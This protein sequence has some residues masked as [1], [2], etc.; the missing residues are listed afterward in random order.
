MSLV[1]RE[2]TAADI[3]AVVPLH[4]KTWRATYEGL[5]SEKELNGPTYEI[6]ERQW[7]K[8]F[9]VAD[10]NRFH[11]VVE[12]ETG[13]L[14]GFAVGRPSDHPEFE[15]ELNKIYL[16]RE[17]QRQ[18]LGRRLVG[19][20]VRR[21]LSRGV[22]SMWVYADGRTASCKFYEALGGEKLDADPTTGNYGWRDLQRLAAIC[23][24]E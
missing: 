15:G 12:D 1:I 23:T 2:A 11:F 24:E 21:F 6:R 13:Q 17:Y 3:P 4:L 18:G 9:E 22:T 7:R 5:L 8:A 14:V 20:I 10:G 16:P 19:H